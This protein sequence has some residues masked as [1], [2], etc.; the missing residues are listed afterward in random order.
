MEETIMTTI[1]IAYP[2]IQ[3]WIPAALNLAK[4]IYES[5]YL[6]LPKLSDL[7]ARPIIGGMI[8]VLALANALRAALPYLLT[9]V[10]YTSFLSNVFMLLGLV[11]N[12]SVVLLFTVLWLTKFT[13]SQDELKADL[14]WLLLGIGIKNLAWHVATILS[15]SILMNFERMGAYGNWVWLWAVIYGVVLYF[16]FQKGGKYVWSKNQVAS[17]PKGKK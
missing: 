2:N 11:E 6:R 3:N 17:T 14:T 9:V 10:D 1:K 4:S 13:K 5:I 7:P 16:I 12:F 15:A 8:L